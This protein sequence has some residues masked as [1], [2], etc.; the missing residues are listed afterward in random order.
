MVKFFVKKEKELNDSN[1]SEENF[2]VI[3]KQIRQKMDDENL[4]WC[5]STDSNANGKL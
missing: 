5:I 2:S 1:L 4:N 3:A